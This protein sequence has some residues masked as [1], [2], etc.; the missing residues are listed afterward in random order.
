MASQY[1]VQPV[2]VHQERIAV[3][4][5]NYMKH[6]NALRRQKAERLGVETDGKYN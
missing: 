2:N 4:C 5:G 1:K 6:T 3:Y